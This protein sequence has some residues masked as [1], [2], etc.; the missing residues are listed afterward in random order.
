MRG[1]VARSWVSRAFGTFGL[2]GIWCLEALNYAVHVL[3]RPQPWNAMSTYVGYV[4]WFLQLACL[5]HCQSVDP[6]MATKE[7]EERALS[8]EVSASVCSRSG[9]L[10]PARGVYVRRAGGVVLGCD[11][12]CRWLG[13]PIGYRNRKAFVLFVLYSAVFCAVG[14]VHSAYAVVCTLAPTAPSDGVTDATGNLSSSPS[15]WCPR[16]L[17]VSY[18]GLGDALTQYSISSTLTEGHAAAHMATASILHAVDHAVDAGTLTYTLLLLLTVPANA[19]AAVWL[20]SMAA[21]Q[22]YLVARNRTTLDPRDRRYDVGLARN[23]RQVFGDAPWLWLLP[24][25]SLPR[26]HGSIAPPV[27]VISVTGTDYHSVQAT[28]LWAHLDGPKHA[29]IDPHTTRVGRVH[30]RVLCSVSIEAHV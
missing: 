16:P 24:F 15:V 8:G 21:E 30:G 4:I 5:W 19:A 11:H 7:W 14:C 22:V 3:I 29:S 27:C 9:R 17:T 13:T 25:H 26:R 6:G 23:V 1:A 20:S 12:Y 2:V 10:V 28:V 18:H